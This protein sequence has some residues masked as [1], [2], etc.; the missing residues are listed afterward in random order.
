[1]SEELYK[2]MA[3]SIIDG[4]GGSSRRLRQASTEGNGN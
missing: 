2:E 3:Q 4:A 1:M